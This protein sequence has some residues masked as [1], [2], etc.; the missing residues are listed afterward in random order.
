MAGLVRTAPLELAARA[1]GAV[2]HAIDK[3]VDTRWDAARERAA[4][5]TG[6]TIDEQVTA[7]GKTFA[8]ELGA[9]GAVAG[10]TAAVPGIG[11]GAAVAA[12]L[13]ELGYFTLRSSELVLTIGAARA[14]RGQRAGAACVDRVGAL[15][16]KRRVGG[17]PTAGG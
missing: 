8:R 15:V 7:L 6:S 2:V 11:T 3:A 12:S 10:G 17:V 14:L 5:V 1:G 16:R 13:T 9:A 4:R